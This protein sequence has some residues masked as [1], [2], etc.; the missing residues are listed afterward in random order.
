M[1]RTGYDITG[2]PPAP[3]V[4]ISDS[5]CSPSSTDTPYSTST[6]DI[7]TP[8]SINSA[9]TPSVEEGHP[10]FPLKGSCLQVVMAAFMQAEGR[11]QD[12]PV[13]TEGIGSVHSSF[14]DPSDRP[15]KRGRS[16]KC[17][18]VVTD[19]KRIPLTKQGT[20]GRLLYL[21]CPYAK[22]DPVRYRDCYR[23]DLSRIR[24][25]KQHLARCHRKPPYCPRCNDTFEDEDDKDSHIRSSTCPLRPTIVIEGISDKQKDELGK[26]VSGKMPQD[27]QWFAVFDILFYPHPHPKTPYRDKELSQDL[28]AF[29]DFMTANGPTILADLLETKGVISS[30]LPSE[31]R[32]LAALKKGL[33]E[34]GLHLIIERWTIDTA[35]AVG[36][37]NA[38]LSP[39]PSSVADSGIAM[40]ADRLQSID[41]G[42]SMQ[43]PQLADLGCKTDNRSGFDL[44][45][46]SMDH[47]KQ[48][49]D[50]GR[51]RSTTSNQVRDTCVYT[52]ILQID[53]VADSS[54]QFMSDE[55][56]T[57]SNMMPIDQ[58]EESAP[59]TMP[60]Q[61]TSLDCPTPLPAT[62]EHLDLFSIDILDWPP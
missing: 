27:Q 45:N 19:E 2:L 51:H 42:I 23:Y 9:G 39:P 30:I 44:I 33:L 6:I 58:P 47:N 57:P 25:V 53:G 62:Y 31:E 50:E 29:Q 52:E 43:T 32:D 36:E 24:D 54:V 61:A 40:Q 35:E 41:S 55:Y 37:T 1:G 11:K 17:A 26:K 5:P 12:H 16:S 34:E 38:P 59:S 4:A 10:L 20:Q 48:R 13:S 49:E 14:G 56:Y 21:A 60:P 8:C 7:G 3:K 46:A 28:C 15:R 18:S 22:K